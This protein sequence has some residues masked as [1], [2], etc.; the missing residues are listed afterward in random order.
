MAISNIS[1]TEADI[2]TEL[3][4]NH[5]VETAHSAP[6]PVVPQTMFKSIGY[7]YSLLFAL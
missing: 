3:Y 2:D 5:L 1:Y 6:F 7:L 4:F